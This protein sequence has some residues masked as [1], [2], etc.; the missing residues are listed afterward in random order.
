MLGQ[1]EGPGAG[2]LPGPARVVF[3]AGPGNGISS[4]ATFWDAE[5][6]GS[7]VFIPGLGS[8][9]CKKGG[10]NVSHSMSNA[11]PDQPHSPPEQLSSSS[12][13]ADGH[14]VSSNVW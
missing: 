6:G 14:A 5:E 2:A 3:R 4:S 13:L 10:I 11:P 7:V 1:P 12:M 8:S 9:G